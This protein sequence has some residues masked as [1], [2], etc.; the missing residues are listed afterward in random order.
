LLAVTAGCD[1]DDVLRIQPGDRPEHPAGVAAVR[2]LPSRI[3]YR[4][5]ERV[6]TLVVIENA[7][8]VGTIAFDLRYNPT[9]LQYVDAVEEAFM[10]SDGSSTVFF[11]VPTVAGDAVR[12]ALSRT[13]DAPGISGTGFLAVF[14]FLAVDVGGTSLAF[15]AASVKDPQ[16]RF[17]PSGFSAVSVSVV[18]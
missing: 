6:M 1:D 17:L 9:V 3:Q 12:V 15:A 2:L 16:G 5:G 11:A 14:E 8:N 18:P 10:S 4:V 7:A 13:A